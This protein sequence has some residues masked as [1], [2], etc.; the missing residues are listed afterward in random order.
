MDSTEFLF[1]VA[2][3]KRRNDIGIVLEG[4]DNA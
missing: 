2:L 3:M 4:I 1:K